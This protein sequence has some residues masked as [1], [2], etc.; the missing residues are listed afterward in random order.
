MA[1]TAGEVNNIAASSIDWYFKKGSLFE[2]A[3]QE[4]PLLSY[5][6]GKK[7]TFPGGKGN[8]SLGVRGEYGAAGVNDSVVGYTHTDSVA[9]Y[10]PATNQRANYPWREHHIGLTMTHTELKV[11]GIS[12]VDTNGEK[13]S[14]HTNR[15][16]HVL[17]G[18]LDT[19][20]SDLAERYAKT[21]NALFWGDGVADAKAIA[22]LRHII[23]KNPSTGTVGGLARGTYSWWR[24][25]ARTT[26]FGA[27]VSGTPAL[28]AHGGDKITSATANGGAL[29]Q[30]LQVEQRQLIRYGGKPTKAFCGSDFLGAMETEMRANG[31]YTQTGF[32][33]ARD[34][35][36]GALSWAGTTFEYDP[37]LDDLSESKFCYW[38]DPKAIFLMSMEDEWLHHHSPAR[39]AT[40]FVLYRSITA[41]GQICASQMN[42]SIVLEIA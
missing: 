8:I 25:R 24:N 31:Q 35:S 33:G 38:F 37:T 11:D 12:V 17:V 39:P 6:E 42:S 16:M 18:L 5:M 13:T 4:K 40:Q 3:I 19:K 21:M 41:T 9:F 2:Q 23:S 10:T 36:M 20:L 30:A 22:G 26:L 15:E 28:A 29:L 34:V 7:K 27:A 1:F 32:T 14:E